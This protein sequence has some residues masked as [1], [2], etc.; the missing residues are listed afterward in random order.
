[1]DRREFCRNA[2]YLGAGSALLPA[3]GLAAPASGFKF[4][5][6]VWP[7]EKQA[8]L[9]RCLEIAAEAGYTGVEFTSETEQWSAAD[10]RRILQKVQAL[11]LT[12]DAV[13]SGRPMLADPA[14]MGNVLQTVKDHIAIA[15]ELDSPQ[16]IL[17]P[18]KRVAGQSQ[19]AKTA[20]IT[21]ALKRVG[22]LMDKADMQLAF[23][24]I[25][26]LEYKDVAIS[27]V[28]EAFP[29]IRA[30]GNP[31][32]K[33]LY[34]FYH[35]QRAAGDLIDKLEGNIEWLGLVHIADVPGRHQPG[36]GEID[37]A[38]IFRKLAELKYDRYIAMEF[39]PSG[40]PVAALRG[41]RQLALRAEQ[42][43]A[44]AAG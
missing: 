30:V 29:I 14:A 24:P 22:E 4:S 6:M 33:V 34:D 25:D 27:S 15:K 43:G 32:V 23:E 40:D 31:R 26:G 20:A 1:M 39:F 35:E 12:V 44:S 38:N 9:E 17:T 5:V 37:Y 18:G 19:E 13:S 2:L 8:P 16:L 11:G 21:E 10:K 41:A 36:T 42:A 7:L 3:R 28:G